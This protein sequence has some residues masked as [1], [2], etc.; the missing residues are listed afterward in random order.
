M[1]RKIWIYGLDEGDFGVSYQRKNGTVKI[2]PACS[3]NNPRSVTTLVRGL[4]DYGGYTPVLD[5]KPSGRQA[6]LQEQVKKALRL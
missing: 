5:V 6:P 4:I 2:G 1:L 3:S